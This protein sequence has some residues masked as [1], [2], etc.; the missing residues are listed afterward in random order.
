[1]AS[2]PSFVHLHVHSHYS[3]LDGACKIPE[4]VETAKRYGMPAVA[5]TDHGNLFG[6]VEF[7]REAT[8][9]GVKPILGYEAY[10]A[11]RSRHDKE[12]TGGIRGAAFHLT[13]LAENETGYRNLIRLATLAYLEGFYYKPRIDWQALAEHHEGLICLSGCL[14]SQVAHHIL[15]ERMDQARAVAARYH[16]LFGDG[17]YFLEVQENGLDDQRTVNEA[18]LELSRALGIPLV[19]TNDIHYMRRDDASAH[20]VLLCINTSKLLTDED[21]MSFGSDQFYF[22]SPREMAERFADHPEA[23][24]TTVAI[25]ER[26]EVELDFSRRHFP[27]FD[28][29]ELTNDEHLRGLARAELAR[30]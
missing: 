21:R 7:Y 15:A 1:M 2:P 4:L 24:A 29:G 16:E 12:S 26:C 28:S 23:L 25:A 27:P 20:E 5:V 13:L 3:L 14:K 18:E 6:A 9:A 11:P 22:A 19:A 8:A 30:W 10:V 17:R